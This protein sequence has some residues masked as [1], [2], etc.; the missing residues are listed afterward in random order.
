MF[1]MTSCGLPLPLG[2]P[3]PL[4]PDMNGPLDDRRS[5]GSSRPSARP[6]GSMEAEFALRICSCSCAH[7][8]LERHQRRNGKTAPFVLVGSGKGLRAIV[9][10]Q[11]A[12]HSCIGQLIARRLCGLRRWRC[13]LAGPICLSRIG[14]RRKHMRAAVYLNGTWIALM[15]REWRGVTTRH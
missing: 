8:P 15:P 3:W 4:Q 9:R 6:H 12:G 7:P 14:V 2:S 5:R 13:G 10:D 1:E 11:R